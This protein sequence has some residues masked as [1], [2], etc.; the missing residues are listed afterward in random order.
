MRRCADI[1]CKELLRHIPKRRSKSLKSQCRRAC[2]PWDL[3]RNLRRAIGF[4]QAPCFS[5]AY[6]L[7]NECSYHTPM[8]ERPLA[9]QSKPLETLMK[10]QSIGLHCFSRNMLWKI[11]WSKCIVFTIATQIIQRYSKTPSGGLEIWPA[12]ANQGF[13]ASDSSK[14]A[15][16]DF[17]LLGGERHRT[18][19]PPLSDKS[20]CDQRW[21]HSRTQSQ[22]V[23]LQA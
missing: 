18:A 19:K 8:A 12:E 22:W 9:T 15:L 10:D 16:S 23:S 11:I 7:P 13:G 5:R 1:S 21:N 2:Q 4:D 14:M 3:R 6:L 17:I 20:T